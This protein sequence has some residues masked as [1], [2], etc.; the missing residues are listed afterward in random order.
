M[1]AFKFCNA[2]NALSTLDVAAKTASF[3]AFSS[4]KNEQTITRAAQLLDVHV[5]IRYVNQYRR[6][7]SRDTSLRQHTRHG[8]SVVTC[9]RNIQD[10]KAISPGHRRILQNVRCRRSM[11]L[12]T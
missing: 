5:T 12:P 10:C 11:T 3:L 8:T 6:I 4:D 7:N 2:Y 1:G 9:D